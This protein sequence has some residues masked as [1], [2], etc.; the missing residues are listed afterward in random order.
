MSTAL[1]R[2]VVF[3]CLT[4]LAITSWAPLAGADPAPSKKELARSEEQ[5][6]K[7]FDHFRAGR[8]AAARP[9]FR[10]SLEVQ[11]TAAVS[12]YLGVCEDKLGDPREAFRRLARAVALSV[13]GESGE[14]PTTRKVVL[15]DAR[16]LAREVDAKLAKLTFRWP[17]EPPGDVTLTVD[18][19]PLSMAEA[20]QGPLRLNPGMH[21]VR[22]SATGRKPYELALELDA[23][24]ER[25]VTL[26]LSPDPPPE[27]TLPPR[28][29][30]P[31]PEPPP[32][33][34]WHRP[35]GF[36]G[37]GLGVA[38]LGAGVYSSLRMEALEDRFNSKPYLIYRSPSEEAPPPGA[39]C[40][41]ARQGYESPRVGA[42]DAAD[43]R[44]AC[45]EA[46]RL[47]VFQYVFYGT[48]AALVGAGAYFAFLAPSK[49]GGASAGSSWR[50]VPAASPS[51]AG[52]TW[53]LTF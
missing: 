45:A 20:S 19:E 51:T 46:G 33:G 4:A 22:A 44:D 36:V 31:P 5:A 11:E 1:R 7:G 12:Y 3:C 26:E 35:V 23:G 42:V 6:R 28:A 34:A 25:H 32:S 30:K 10:G 24:Q 15:E 16:E 14:S 47:K 52:A 38:L 49:A 48:G 43:F 29:L 50:V 37:L 39:P 2:S 21:K 40:A 53:T 18:D 13:S 9:Y 27:P 41:S 17:N 8:W